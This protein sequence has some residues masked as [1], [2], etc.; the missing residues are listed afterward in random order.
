MLAHRAQDL[1]QRYSQ[2]TVFHE[3]KDR[4]LMVPVAPMAGAFINTSSSSSSLMVARDRPQQQS[5]QAGGVQQM[6]VISSNNVE[7]SNGS[8]GFEGETAA[9]DTNDS[10]GG[11][12]SE[13]AESLAVQQAAAAE[14]KRATRGPVSHDKGARSRWGALFERACSLLQR[15]S[16][17]TG[18]GAGSSSSGGSSASSSGTGGGG[19][20]TVAS[21]LVAAAVQSQQLLQAKA[22][23]KQGKG[24][25]AGA[26]DNTA[27]AAGG[28]SSSSSTSDLAEAQAILEE[29][30]TLPSIVNAPGECFAETMRALL[31]ELLV[32][33]T[34]AR[35]WDAEVADGTTCPHYLHTQD[36][37]SPTSPHAKP[38]YLS[39]YSL[40]NSISHP[41]VAPST[42]SL[43]SLALYPAEA[44][45][46]ISLANG[47]RF[48]HD[49]HTRFGATAAF[50]THPINANASGSNSSHGSSSQP[51]LWLTAAS[52]AGSFTMK[53]FRKLVKEGAGLR[54][55][56][57]TERRLKQS[58]A[59]VDQ[60][61]DTSR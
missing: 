19:P 40:T 61:P 28:V 39:F 52:A 7:G 3:A 59:K 48:T 57:D 44:L 14:D 30:A 50:P 43:P 17:A 6:I 31:G 60:S 11:K 46:A 22:A 33:M 42:Q 4:L 51:C 41:F 54:L 1:A 18:V 32:A 16:K 56:T 5:P 15:T 10:I 53:D 21:A 29:A 25:A 36:I 24:K 26:S 2:G 37:I 45:L 27:A 20:H 35:A 47:D 34:D 55:R 58:V 13:S 23:S 12:S 38:L 49:T 9:L 8:N